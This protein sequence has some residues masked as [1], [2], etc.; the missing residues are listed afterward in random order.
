MTRCIH[1]NVAAALLMTTALAWNL[2]VLAVD[3]LDG[4]KA[5]TQH[6]AAA[7]IERLPSASRPGALP[8]RTTPLGSDPA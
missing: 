6:G 7:S 5:R 1:H 4:G 3:T 8:M 2:P